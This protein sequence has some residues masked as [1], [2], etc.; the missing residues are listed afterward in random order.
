MTFKPL[1][2]AVLYAQCLCVSPVFA[3]VAIDPPFPTKPLR[4][5]VPVAT[6]GLTDSLGR[7]LALKLEQRLG[8]PVVVENKGGAGGVVGTIAAAASSADGHTILMTFMGPAAVRQALNSKTI[9]YST[10]RDFAPVS[11]VARFPLLL[12]VG[13]NF[14]TKTLGEFIALAKTK[15]ADVSYASAGVGSTG[16]LAM[17]LFQRDIGVKILH[18][19]Y[20]GE[21]PAMID[22]ME[23]R[24]S[25]LWMSLS[26]AYP[27]IKDGKLRA[28]GIANKERHPGAPA[29]PTIGEAGLKGFE[30]TG[31]Y[32]MLVPAAT[33]APAVQI[34]AKEFVAIVNDPG[35]KRQYETYGI[36]Q[37]AYGPEQ[38]GHLIK[39]EI[40]KWQRLGTDTGLTID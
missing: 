15:P 35:M 10:L 16:H 20:K 29:I 30:F 21:A 18:V 34:L 1:I 5:I 36:E 6:G 25:A 24:V 28:L 22:V 17:E 26:V 31:W 7:T 40:D 9:P 23:G 27:Q 32:G 33:P 38:F 14:Q 39:T 37:A 19:P 4:L 3:Q 13:S 12:V 11:L 8:Q 2:A